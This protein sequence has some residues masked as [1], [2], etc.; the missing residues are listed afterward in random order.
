MHKDT[1]IEEQIEQDR[2]VLIQLFNEFGGSGWSRKDQWLIHDDIGKWYG[3]ETSKESGRV[4]A[5]N[6]A[7]NGLKGP[8]PTT[9]LEYL[10][11]LKVLNLSTNDISGCIPQS[12]GYLTGLVCLDLSKNAITGYVPYSLIYC[13]QLNMIDFSNNLIFGAEIGYEFSSN[14]PFINLKS[15]L[16]FEFIPINYNKWNINNLHELQSNKTDYSKM[17]WNDFDRIYPKQMIS[18]HHKNPPFQGPVLLGAPAQ[19]IHQNLTINE[20]NPLCMLPPPL[21][22]ITSLCYTCQSMKDYITCTNNNDKNENKTDK[23]LLYWPS[24]MA[25]YMM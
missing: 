21:N 25:D 1:T 7:N 11:E 18:Y 17:K 24:F 16:P 2:V 12:L 15:K 14:N 10:A 13:T 23:I 20:R 9:G 3:I 19:M 6:L 22:I 5:I 8:F 4:T